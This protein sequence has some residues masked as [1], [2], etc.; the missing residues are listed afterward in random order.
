MPRTAL[1]M[2]QRHEAQAIPELRHAPA[3]LV[4]A[5]AADLHATEGAEASGPEGH[6]AEHVATDVRRRH[7]HRRHRHRRHRH[8]R[9]RHRRHRHSRHRLRNRVFLPFPMARRLHRL[10]H[11][12]D[13]MHELLERL[14]DRVRH[15]NVHLANDRNRHRH[16]A[17]D[18]HFLNLLERHVH[19]ARDR[20]VARD[21][22]RNRH[23]HLDLT[24]NLP[25]L[26][27]FYLH[28]LVLVLHDRHLHLDLLRHGHVAVLRHRDLHI[29][30]D[31]LC[32]D[33]GNGHLDDLLHRALLNV[34]NLDNP[35]DV[36]DLRHRDLALLDDR[37]R[38]VDN[39]LLD[40][41]LGNLDD[42]LDILDLRDLDLTLLHD[43]H[44]DAADNF[45]RL[46]V[47]NF[48]DAL[49]V[50]NVGH[51]DGLLVHHRHMTVNDL[52]HRVRDPNWAVFPVARARWMLH[53]GSIQA[54]VS[55]GHRRGHHRRR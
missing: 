28:V 5:H 48:D 39:A 8:R 45:L 37:D 41:H 4:A 11:V 38:L 15:V 24:R 27:D 53:H 20:D 22:H 42:L 49:L 2:M 36:L 21:C 55:H 43:R 34:R 10:R 12:T 25:G 44:S 23:R 16:L 7:R 31:H 19:V 9:H 52:L 30:V 46:H 50:L 17:R 35:L 51:L 14:V 54:G 33:M 13:R 1:L 47:R 26:L 32:L 29:L 18:L 3:D 6:G 40:L